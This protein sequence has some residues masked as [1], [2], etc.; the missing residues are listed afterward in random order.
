MYVIAEEVPFYCHL[1][2]SIL[3]IPQTPYSL[4]YSVIP[5]PSESTY[6]SEC[7]SH[8]VTVEAISGSYV[9]V[10]HQSLFKGLG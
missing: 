3:C 9:Q 7:Y 4:V 10:C 8:C 2:L 1:V 5:T 6:T